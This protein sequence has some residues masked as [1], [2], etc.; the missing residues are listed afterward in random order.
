MGTLYKQLI[1]EPLIFLG[2]IIIM[3]ITVILFWVSLN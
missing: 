2:T 3:D 1:I